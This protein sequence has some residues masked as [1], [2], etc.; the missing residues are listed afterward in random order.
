MAKS[1]YRMFSEKIEI[2]I[3]LLENVSNSG[4]D[5]SEGD[6]CVGG[7]GG[8]GY[9]CVGGVGGDGVG[10]GGGGCGESGCGDSG[11]GG[12]GV[13]GGDDSGGGDCCDDGDTGYF[14]VVVAVMVEVVA[15]VMVM[16]ALFV[17]L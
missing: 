2:V 16:L 5:G 1:K 8:R 9:G 13:G 10:G 12:D 6:G 7:C 4:V 15:E 17:V 14:G 3:T 11:C